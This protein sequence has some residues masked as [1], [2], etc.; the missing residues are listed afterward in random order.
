MILLF[1]I[2]CGVARLARYNSS[3]ETN[4]NKQGIV[5]CFEGTPI[6]STLL[7]VMIIFYYVINYGVESILNGKIIICGY[8]LHSFT[9]FYLI[10]GILQINK[11]LKIP[12]F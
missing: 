9:L 8:S 2:N 12:K 6:P 3:I 7:I 1:F 11:S 5:D 10:S 4:K